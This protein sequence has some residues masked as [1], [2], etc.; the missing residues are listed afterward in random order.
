MTLKEVAREMAAHGISGMPVLDEELRIVG[1]ISEADL[2]AKEA[3]RPRRT[4][5]FCDASRT[6]GRQTRSAATTPTS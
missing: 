1:V 6:S 4:G 2:I 5:T 3:R